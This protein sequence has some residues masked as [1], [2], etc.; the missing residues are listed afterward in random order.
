MKRFLICVKKICLEALGVLMIFNGVFIAFLAIIGED[1]S[2]ILRNA[3]LFSVVSCILGFFLIKKQ[4]SKNEKSEITSKS[5][6]RN[7]YEHSERMPTTIEIGE[8]YDK[9]LPNAVKIVT[10]DGQASITS[11]QKKLKIGYSEAARIINEM[12]ELRIISSFDGSKPRKVLMKNINIIKKDSENKKEEDTEK[13]TNIKTPQ[14]I[15]SISQTQKIEP[16]NS[17]SVFDTTCQNIGYK[18]YQYPPIYLLNRQ[19]ISRLSND[20]QTILWKRGEAASADTDYQM[21]L[22]CI[23]VKRDVFLYQFS[24]KLGTKFS[25]I[26][27]SAQDIAFHLGI[28]SINILPRG[29]AEKKWDIEQESDIIIPVLRTNI[30][31]IYIRELI[32]SENFLNSKAEIP[33]I[34]GISEGNTVIADLSSMGNLLIAGTTG[35]GKSMLLNSILISLMYK[36]APENLKLV[37]IDIN[38]LEMPFYNK[39]PHMLI[40]TVTDSENVYPILRWITNQVKERLEIFRNFGVRNI[41]EYNRKVKNRSKKSYPHI[42]VIIDSLEDLQYSDY[43]SRIVDCLSFIAAYGD[44]VGIHLIICTEYP[45]QCTIESSLKQYIKSRI[46]LTLT[47]ANASFSVLGVKGAES[48]HSDGEMLYLPIMKSVPI[49][50][51]SAYVSSEEILAVIDFINTSIPQIKNDGEIE[52]EKSFSEEIIKFEHFDLMIEN[53]NLCDNNCKPIDLMDGKEFERFCAELLRVCG[54]TAI[55]LTQSTGDQGVDII[56]KKEEIRYAFQCK[57]YKSPLGNSSIQEVF[58]GKEFYNC[59]VGVV[60]TN[61]VFTKGAIELA[62]K[63]NVQLWDRNTIHH[64][65]TSTDS[66]KNYTEGSSSHSNST[67]ILS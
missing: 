49:R 31:E 33:I 1:D 63:I 24:L 27:S 19:T 14:N 59:S 11:L 26:N 53:Q 56:A 13:P 7:Y 22:V 34:L 39:A 18:D 15:S 35:S 6:E 10:E 50:V 40:P 55:Q 36:M 42:C 25:K 47:S 66:L 16:E 60:M 20:E 51:K 64:L 29:E 62:Q 28:Q 46:A 54:F 3:L 52:S 43:Y 57:C 37:L 4:N 17:E 38:G 23:S 30:P 58:A 65:I 2:A 44:A 32:E 12:E 9:L 5:N 61:S 21:R 41:P 45:E 67:R 8:E 48:L